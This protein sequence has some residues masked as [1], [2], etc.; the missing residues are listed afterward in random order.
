M[1]LAGAKLTRPED[2]GAL[3]ME[4]RKESFLTACATLLIDYSQRLFAEGDLTPESFW[5][6]QGREGRKLL[7]MLHVARNALLMESPNVSEHL[8]NS[9]E[10]LVALED[11]TV[12]VK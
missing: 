7:A 3:Y 4:A 5:A 9:L 2:F 12:V 10:G 11:G 1:S 8:R 6:A